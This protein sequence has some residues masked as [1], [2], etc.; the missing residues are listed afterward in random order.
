MYFFDHRRLAASHKPRGYKR[1]LCRRLL[2]AGYG[3]RLK[4]EPI[5]SNC[6]SQGKSQA[7]PDGGEGHSVI[8][9]GYPVTVLR[10]AVAPLRRSNTKA[11]GD[12]Q[13]SSQ[14]CMSGT[15][16]AT[17]RRENAGS[18]AFPKARQTRCSLCSFVSVLTSRIAGYVIRMSGG[19]GGALSDGCPYPDRRQAP[20]VLLK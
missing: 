1:S 11:R 19:V 16:P 12:E 15:S 13:K 4:G 10:K 2:C 20:M 9:T 5:S 7:Q 18:V 14:A 6:G 3:T 17:D 8:T